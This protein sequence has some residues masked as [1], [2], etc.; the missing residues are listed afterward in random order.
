MATKREKNS[1]WEYIIKRAKLLDKPISQTFADEA[2]GDAWAAKIE[3]MLDR[4]I[5]PHELTEKGA[6]YS[7]LGEVIADYLQTREVSQSDKGLLNVIYGRI[8]TTRVL[9]I[10]YKWVESWISN[11]KV[12]LN[13]KPGT[14]RHHVGALGRCFDWAGN[15]NV[16]AFIINPIRKLPK[17]YATYNTKDGQLAKAFDDEHEAQ[18]DTERDR[19]L[20]EG[21]DEQIRAVMHG[22]KPAHRQRPMDLDY[23]MSEAVGHTVANHAAPLRI[24]RSNRLR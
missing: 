17:G 15:R 21:E 18:E 9:T 16:S 22:A 12:E 24:A 1:G 19:R 13:L 20:K 6:Q 8:G 23:T 2:E 11:M 14:I 10:N 5:V 4:G 3:A 7:L